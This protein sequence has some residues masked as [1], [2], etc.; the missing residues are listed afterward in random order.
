[1]P[2]LYVPTLTGRGD[3]F[4]HLLRLVSVTDAWISVL[5]IAEADKEEPVT[6][7]TDDAT[8]AAS[9]SGS[10]TYALEFVAGLVDTS[11]EGQIV[12]RYR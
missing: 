8:V 5:V 3:D 2:T 4:G 12:H 1:M 9:G 7:S 6:L 11:S 10:V